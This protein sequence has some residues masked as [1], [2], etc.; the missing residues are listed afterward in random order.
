MTQGIEYEYDVFLSYR[1]YGQ[2]H[3]WVKDTFS[4]MFEHWLGEELGADPRIFWDDRIE[5]GSDWPQALGYALARSR[6]LVSLFSRQYFY[7]R[8]CK[9][10]LTLMYAR[11]HEC[12]FG[13]AADSPDR[14]IVPALIHDGED[15]PPDAR[16]IQ[17]AELQD[18]A[19][20]FMGKDSPKQEK[21]SD[22]IKLWTPDVRRAIERAPKYDPAW[23]TLAV[24]RFVRLFEMPAAEQKQIV[25][26]SLAAK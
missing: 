18:C 25:P 9:L 15:L 19:D 14:L 24:D 1:R 10:E 12:G 7:S 22:C 2:W 6:V 17:A 26:P 21:L 13:P 20:P 16:R 3:R 4:P 11:E 8:W 23:R 5:S